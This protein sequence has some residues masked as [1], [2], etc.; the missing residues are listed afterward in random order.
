MTGATS[1][2]TLY[3]IGV[4]PGD[5]ELLTVKA[6][7]LLDDMPVIAYPLT[8]SGHSLAHDTAFRFCNPNA[9][10][11]PIEI[12]MA[13]RGADG[14][15]AP[16]DGVY[17]DAASAISARLSDGLDVAYLC[18]GDPLFYGSATYLLGLLR[19]RHKVLVVPGI[20]SVTAAA[21]SIP[22]PLVARSEPLTVLTGPLSNDILR[23]ELDKPGSVAIIKV[24]R[25]FDRLRSVLRA[26]GREDSAWLVEFATRPEQRLT[27]LRDLP[28]GAKPYFSL[29]LCCSGAEQWL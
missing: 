4:G 8:E 7:R 5:P 24:G 18:E 17:E 22:L 9:E 10:M 12:P 11:L 6:V 1:S 27:R 20:T 13:V 14:E 3:L 25:H 2:G 26:S 21:A 19:D 16:K 15:F 23:A 29:I 28:E